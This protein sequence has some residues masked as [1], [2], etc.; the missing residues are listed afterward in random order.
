MG[1]REEIQDRIISNERLIELLHEK[2]AQIYALEAKVNDMER[3]VWIINSGEEAKQ[4]L[5]SK[6]QQ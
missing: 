1:D 2:D 4:K 3:L 6:D 5:F